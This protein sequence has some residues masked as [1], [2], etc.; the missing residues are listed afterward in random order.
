[1]IKLVLVP[2]MFSKH[3]LFVEIDKSLEFIG[4]FFMQELLNE[5]PHFIDIYETDVLYVKAEN[6][7]YIDGIIEI[8]KTIDG[9]RIEV[10]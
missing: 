9:L 5:L 4:N 3:A 1:M 6:N 10:I 7:T 2:S 8:L